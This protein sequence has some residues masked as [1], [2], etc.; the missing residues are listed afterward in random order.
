MAQSGVKRSHRNVI[1][2][3]APLAG[4]EFH[5]QYLQDADPARTSVLLLLGISPHPP[6]QIDVYADIAQVYAVSHQV[7]AITLPQ[8]AYV[9]S[10]TAAGGVFQCIDPLPMRKVSISKTA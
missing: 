10:I 3:G 8:F 2:T 4:P 1:G 7:G 9:C 6:P 5:K